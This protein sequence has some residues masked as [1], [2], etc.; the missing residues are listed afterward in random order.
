TQIP[1][2]VYVVSTK[3]HA[4]IRNVQSVNITFK[5]IKK[6]MLFGYH[7]ESNGNIFIADPEKA[8]VDIY[9]FKDIN[10]L[11]ETILS[12]PARIDIG[13]LVFY[14]ERSKKRYVMLKVAELLEYHGYHSYAKRLV[15]E[16]PYTKYKK[17]R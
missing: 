2:V 14:A 11:D 17:G 1:T 4:S 6:D 10:D 8:I 7:K 12:K 9:Y 15:G 13:K 3:R 16:A 5:K